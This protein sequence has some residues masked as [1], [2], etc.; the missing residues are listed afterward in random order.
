MEPHHERTILPILF[1]R[2]LNDVQR[3]I[4][5]PILA[6]IFDAGVLG[7]VEADVNPVLGLPLVFLKDVN[8]VPPILGHSHNTKGIG[9]ALGVRG[10]H[11]GRRRVRSVGDEVGTPHLDEFNRQFGKLIVKDVHVLC[12]NTDKSA[13]G[14][15]DVR[16]GDNGDAAG[17]INISVL[18]HAFNLSLTI[19]ELTRKFLAP[20]PFNILEDTFLRTFNSSRCD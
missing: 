1:N 15:A 11:Q 3:G 14:V 13:T 2:L 20:Q 19:N 12:L 10:G 8:A 4:E 6:A 16:A 18:V 5:A 9:A 7:V 17:I